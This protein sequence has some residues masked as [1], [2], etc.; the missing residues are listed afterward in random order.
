MEQ[1]WGGERISDLSPLVHH[2]SLPKDAPGMP[3]SKWSKDE[4]TWTILRTPGTD[5]EPRGKQTHREGTACY[6]GRGWGQE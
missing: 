6:L 3:V 4:E 2:C 5:L 1:G